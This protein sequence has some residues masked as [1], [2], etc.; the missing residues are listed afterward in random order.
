MPGFFSKFVAPS[1]LG[2]GSPSAGNVQQSVSGNSQIPGA[3]SPAPAPAVPDNFAEFTKTIGA[4]TAPKLGADGKPVT[5]T[6]KRSV[7]A[8]F[9]DEVIGGK[10]AAVKISNQFSPEDWSAVSVGNPEVATKLQNMFD[11][12]FQKSVAAAFRGAINIS[13]HGLN[14]SFSEFE[15]GKLPE[16]LSKMQAENAIGSAHPMLRDPAMKPILDPMIAGLRQLHPT[17]SEQELQDHA[18]SQLEGLGQKLSG[19]RKDPNK[20][21]GGGVFGPNGST[22]DLSG[23]NGPVERV[24]DF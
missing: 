24:F 21:N 13:E 18:L 1:T 15:S 17:A 7:Y 14:E 16:Y 3:P 2:S 8:D 22:A 5:P 20:L 9:T 23:G 6:A 10:L 12:M 19:L 11:T 4:A